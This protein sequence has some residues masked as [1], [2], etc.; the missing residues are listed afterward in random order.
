MRHKLRQ[1]LT[2]DDVSEG[3][4]RAP[5]GCC[6]GHRPVALLPPEAFEDPTADDVPLGVSEQLFWDPRFRGLGQRAILE[7]QVACEGRLEDYHLWR[8]CCGVPE[9]PQDLKVDELMP[10]H[11]NLDLLDFI[12]FS[13]GCYVGQELLTRTKHRGAVRRRIFTA[14]ALEGASCEPSAPWAPLRPARSSAELQEQQEV[15]LAGEVPKKARS[16]QSK[17]PWEVGTLHSVAGKL[18]LCSL[19]CEG[20][21]NELESFKNS[22]LPPGAEVISNST[23]FKVRPPPYVFSE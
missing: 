18:A 6:T 3:A 12:S 17:R 5:F 21:F 20:A 19:R 15:F 2:I 4:S 23:H 14:E 9:G 22:P 7:T 13:K 1:P 8:V 11:G 16:F 10:L